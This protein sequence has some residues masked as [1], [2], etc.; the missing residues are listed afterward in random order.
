[1]HGVVTWCRGGTHVVTC[2]VHLERL[3]DGELGKKDRNRLKTVVSNRPWWRRH[4]SGNR[5]TDT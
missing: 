5:E 1:M 4:W 2:W 3:I